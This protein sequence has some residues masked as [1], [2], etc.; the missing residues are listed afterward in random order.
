MVGWLQF[1]S[2]SNIQNIVAYLRLTEVLPGFELSDFCGPYE[3]QPLI[4]LNHDY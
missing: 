2:G 4:C 1:E 3:P